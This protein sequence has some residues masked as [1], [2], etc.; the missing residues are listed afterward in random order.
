[1]GAAAAVCIRPRPDEVAGRGESQC[2]GMLKSGL[3]HSLFLAAT[4]RPLPEIGNEADRRN[5]DRAS[6]TRNRSRVVFAANQLLFSSRILM[7]R[8][9][10]SLPWSCSE[11][12]PF[13][14][15]PNLGIEP[16]LLLATRWF[17][18]SLPL[19]NS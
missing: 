2:Y 6:R 16:N 9:A 4:D 14:G 12:C 3:R 8:K 10:T 17:Q 15:L 1:M 5:A 18:S 19:T 13:V 7:L 11:M